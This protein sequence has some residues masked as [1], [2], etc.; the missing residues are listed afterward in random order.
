MESWIGCALHEF[1]FGAGGAVFLVA[2][3]GEATDVDVCKYELLEY[4]Q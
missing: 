1:E 2:W 3:M 4:E